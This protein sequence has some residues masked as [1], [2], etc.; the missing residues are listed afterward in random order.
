[1][2]I[3]EILSAQLDV[4]SRS[5]GFFGILTTARRLNYSNVDF[6]HF[7]H[8]IERALGGSGVGIGYRFGQSDRRN[9]PR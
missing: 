9:L 2:K 7:H 6:A 5:D 1:M 8:R 4:N 3:P